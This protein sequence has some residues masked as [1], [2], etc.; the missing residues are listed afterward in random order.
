MLTKNKIIAV[1]LVVL[2]G[3]A[4]SCKKDDNKLPVN[5]APIPRILTFAPENAG[6]GDLLTIKGLHFSTDPEKNIVRFNQTVVTAQSVSDTAIT[7]VVP[8]LTVKSAGV[9]VRSNG[10]IS[11]RKNLNLVQIKKFQDDFNRANVALVDNTVMPNPLGSVWEIVTGRF[12]LEN[13]QLA[14][15]AGGVE[16][17]MLYRAPEADMKAGSDHF[18]KFSAS[19]TVSGGGSF[20]GVIFHAQPDNKRFY[21]LRTAGKMVQ[22]L[23]TGGN[24][25]GDWA[26]IMINDNFEGFVDN[27]K[28]RVDISSST[29]G[30]IT[31]KLS[32]PDTNGVMLERTVEDPNP[33]TGGVP[34]FYYFGLANPVNIYFDDFSL[35]LQ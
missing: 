32:D 26:A 35:E 10:K 14:T 25:L 24:G 19:V 2:T 13:N 22:L 33:Y 5:N 6:P 12:S 18:F 21:L 28:Y 34:G 29:A 27:K 16:T 15:H 11:N 9:T 7:V 4:G 8:A 20:G 3:T 23:K 1:L 31:V 17:Y 30:K